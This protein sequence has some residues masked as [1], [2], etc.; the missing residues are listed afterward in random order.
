MSEE[1]ASGIPLP[2]EVDLIV[3]MDDWV[4]Y[5]L[6]RN[7]NLYV[8]RCVRVVCYLDEFII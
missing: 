4:L 1:V 6:L 5:V 3:G 7:W 8:E 2:G